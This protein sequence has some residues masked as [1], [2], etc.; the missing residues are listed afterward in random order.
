M[1]PAE[2]AQRAADWALLADEAAVGITTA[3]DLANRHA[4]ARAHDLKARAADHR[5]AADRHELDRR[6]ADAMANTWARVAQALAAADAGGVGESTPPRQ[7]AEGPSRSVKRTRAQNG[8]P[9]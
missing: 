4:D 3:R 8:E 9:G 5:A 7:R 1:T 6:T 2:A